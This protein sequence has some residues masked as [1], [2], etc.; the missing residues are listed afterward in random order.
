[1]NNPTHTSEPARRDDKMS[2]WI[3]FQ[4]RVYDYDANGRWGFTLVKQPAHTVWRQVAKKS[5]NAKRRRRDRSES[6][7]Y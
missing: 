2:P 6:E 5:A 3:N 7:R 1:V 4:Q